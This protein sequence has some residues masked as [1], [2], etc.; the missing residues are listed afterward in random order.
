MA[1][2]VKVPALP[3]SVSDATIAAIHKKVGD[4]VTRDEP[5]L[6]LE[7]D[8]VVL[9]VPSPVTGVLKAVHFQVGDTVTAQQLLAV[10]EEGAAE[11]AVPKPASESAAGIK[12]RFHLGCVDS[13]PNMALNRTKLK[14]RVKKGG[15]PKKMWSILFSLHVSLKQHN[16]LQHPK[17]NK[18]WRRKAPWLGSHVVFRCRD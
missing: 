6:D 18:L 9:E 11:A 13:W 10:I 14:A 1:I 17:K 5:L 8:K 4:K 7:T 16:N 2:E 12:Q 15:L 3:E